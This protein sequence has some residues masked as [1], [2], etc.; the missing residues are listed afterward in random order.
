M[1]PLAQEREFA[2]TANLS[3]R[4]SLRGA[5]EA[6]SYWDSWMKISY[7]LVENVSPACAAVKR[8]TTPLRFSSHNSPLPNVEMARL[9]VPWIQAPGNWETSWSLYTSPEACSVE[10]APGPMSEPVS[11][12][13]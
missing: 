10:M 8:M 1:R 4:G 11:V 6:P 7:R 2:K 9:P 3:T 13:G 5:T 12:N